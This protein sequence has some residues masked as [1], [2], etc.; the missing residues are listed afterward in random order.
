[1]DMFSSAMGKNHPGVSTRKQ[2]MLTDAVHSYVKKHLPFPED[3]A[4]LFADTIA[5]VKLTPPERPFMYGDD[6]DKLDYLDYERACT[7]YDTHEVS[8]KPRR[9]L[10]PPSFGGN[11]VRPCEPK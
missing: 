8:R 9:A 1:M 6:I 4:P 3:L 11:A 2:S 7:K 10:C 5:K